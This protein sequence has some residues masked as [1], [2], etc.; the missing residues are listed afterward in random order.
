M[1]EIREERHIIQIRLLK[2]T[3]TQLLT[4][5][6]MVGVVLHDGLSREESVAHIL[7]AMGYKPVKV[8]GRVEVAPTENP[9]FTLAEVHHM[10]QTYVSDEIAL[11]RAAASMLETIASLEHPT[12]QYVKEVRNE[13]G[14]Y[15]AHTNLSRII[16]LMRMLFP[17]SQL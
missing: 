7:L 5:G 11:L 2:M 17:D 16:G 14:Y 1:Q 3:H 12:K 9:V 10:L 13:L 6:G 4:L 8:T 15:Q